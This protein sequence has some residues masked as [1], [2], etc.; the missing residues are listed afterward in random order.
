MDH[1]ILI[2]SEQKRPLELEN[3]EIRQ[4]KSAIFIKII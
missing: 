3:V 4:L 1:M 2:I